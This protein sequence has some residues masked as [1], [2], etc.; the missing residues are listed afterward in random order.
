[1]TAASPGACWPARHRGQCPQLHRLGCGQHRRY[2]PVVSLAAGITRSSSMPLATI[3][4]ATASVCRILHPRRDHASARR[5]PARS[6]R[7][8]PPISTVRRERRAIG[9]ISTSRALLWQRLLAAD[10]SL[11]PAG[12]VRV[13]F[14]DVDTQ[15]LSFTGTYTLLVEGYIFNSSATPINY[16]FNVQKVTDT[17]A[18]LALGAQVDSAITQAGQQNSYTFSLANAAQ[19]YFDSLTNDGG[20]SWS[21]VGPRGTEI[22]LRS[23]PEL[24]FGSIGRTNPVSAS[25]RGITRSIVDALATI[26]AATASGCRILR[27]QPRS[28]PA[29]RS[30][31][32][33]TRERPPISTSSTR[34]RAIGSIST[35][36]APPLAT[37][38]GG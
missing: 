23:L 26:P 33:S 6:I 2:N 10:R 19:L 28:R 34:A 36:R 17:T 15:T 5:S 1:M 14:S 9:S 30:P 8:P 16:G 4:A 13:S 18:A 38:I 35:S 32:R 29:H 7:G 37:S 22:N 21:L 24:G 20:L 12:L 31:A 3:P 27:R 25:W 11:W